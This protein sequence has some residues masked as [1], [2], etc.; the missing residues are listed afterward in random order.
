[1]EILNISWSNAFV[2]FS[3]GMG[4]VFVVLILL[5]F[6]LNGFS[7][8]FIEKKTE[9]TAAV[10]NIPTEMEAAAI[11]MALHLFYQGTD[12]EN[13]IITINNKTTLWN[14]KIFGLNRFPE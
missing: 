13:S 11:V 1:M 8:L 9:I 4:I 7:W 3:L 14:S 2:V 6:L 12:E 5:V 10:S